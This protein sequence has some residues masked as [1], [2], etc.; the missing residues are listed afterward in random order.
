MDRHHHG[1]RNGP[2]NPRWANV[3]TP[4]QVAERSTRYGWLA[5]EQTVITSSCGMDPRAALFGLS[6][7]P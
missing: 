6:E 1:P 5:P 3:E 7:Q 2:A 4:E